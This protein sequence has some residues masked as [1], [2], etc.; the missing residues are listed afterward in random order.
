MEAMIVGYYIGL[1]IFAI[2]GIQWMA[3]R[4]AKREHAAAHERL[5]RLIASK[6]RI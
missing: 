6:R 1:F 3:L 5:M 4:Q 2:N